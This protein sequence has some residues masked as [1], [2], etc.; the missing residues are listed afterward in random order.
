MENLE[1][2]LRIA[3]SEL[4]SGFST[5]FRRLVSLVQSVPFQED[6]IRRARMR[7]I[8]Y[9]R[10][11]KSILYAK[12]FANNVLHLVGITLLFMKNGSRADLLDGI[13]NLDV[14]ELGKLVYKFKV[15]H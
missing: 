14:G 11:E 10:N 12:D 5:P 15:G 1:N 13:G 9:N 6:D 4:F 3:S 2:C 8:A 7:R